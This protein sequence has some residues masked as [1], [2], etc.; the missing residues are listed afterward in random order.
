MD[1]Q[2]NEM[3]EAVSGLAK[4]IFAGSTQPWKDLVDAQIMDLE[5]TLEIASLLVACGRAGARVPLFE[6]LVLGAPIAKF[7]EAPAPGTV[8]TA[9]LVEAHS[10]DPRRA[11]TRCEGG[12][13]YGE[14]V[15]VPWASQAS[16]IVVPAT[17]GVYVANLADCRIEEGTATHDDP[18][19]TVVFDGTPCERLGGDE[20]LDWWL[21]RVDVGVCALLFG[22]AKEALILTAKYVA[23]RQQFGRPIGSFQ[24]VQQRA[25]D[26]W[27]DLQAM[28]VCLWQAAYRVDAELDSARER[29]IARYWAAEG[30]HRVTAAAQH[31]HGGFGFDRDYP[32]HRYF[33]AVKQHEFLLGG[34]NQQ[35][36]QL[37]DLVAQA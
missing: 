22:L 25:A 35:L 9:G 37:G 31:L 23:D 26:A 32:L 30:A 29:A 24:A 1:W 7:G 19:G 16:R 6:T 14:K 2:E 11:T 12:K 21:P 36:E 20:V 33:L 4:Q 13:L 34:A 10:R 27:I 18:V 15:C 5:G 17:D 8:L 3:Q 28:E